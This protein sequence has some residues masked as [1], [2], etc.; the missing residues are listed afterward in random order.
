MI[1]VIWCHLTALGIPYQGLSQEDRSRLSSLMKIICVVKPVED[2]S[3]FPLAMYW[4]RLQGGATAIQNLQVGCCN[5]LEQ[6]VQ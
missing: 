2:I 6:V 5:Y 3:K 1:S 4:S